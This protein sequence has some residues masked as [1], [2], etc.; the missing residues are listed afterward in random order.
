MAHTQ[1]TVHSEQPRALVPAVPLR[2]GI[3]AP[4]WFE[5]PPAG[6]GGTEAVVAAIVNGLADRGHDVTLVA[7][8]QPRT[9]ATQFVQVFDKPPCEELGV[10]PLPEVI[11]AARAAQ[12]L[13]GE[14]FDV[15]HDHS[16]AG[17]L[18]AVGRS[19]PT[20]STVHG[21]I[22]GRNA[23]YLTLLGRN[24]NLVAISEAQRSTGPG[25]NWVGTVHNAVDVGTFPFTPRKTDTL[26]WIGRFAPEKGAHTAIEAARAAGRPIVLAGKLSE[27]AERDFFDTVIR[28]RLGRTVEFVGE[29]T[30]ELKRELFATSA[31]LLF[32]IEWEEPFGMVMIE[33]LAC[34]TPV[35][36]TRR[37]SVPEIIEDGVT[38]VL[39]DRAEELPAAIEKAAALK[40][41]AC[42]VSAEER[43]DVSVMVR[44]YERVFRRVVAAAAGHREF[45]LDRRDH[46]GT[47]GHRASAGATRLN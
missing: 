42:R 47:G 16:L 41:L 32:P 10:S 37:A 40:P 27:P 29:A 13:T 6:Y 46:T 3:I 31:A 33:S 7:A 9:R 18:L 25:L 39:V 36:A 5:I 34:G 17:P 30:A 26:L 11:M 2:I 4:P 19:T 21:P 38:G 45:A 44:G 43:F 24:I 22:V 1:R 15:I 8:G 12:A 28:P 14:E 35:V 23:D 20:V